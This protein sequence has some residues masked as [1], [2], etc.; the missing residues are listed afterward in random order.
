MP[1]EKTKSYY[2]LDGYP[3][4]EVYEIDENVM[5]PG[6]IPDE[7]A[8]FWMKDCLIPVTPHTLKINNNNMNES[9]QLVDGEPLTIPKRDKAQSISIDFMFPHYFY[10][11]RDPFNCFT[12]SKFI[13]VKNLTD[14][15]WNMKSNREP[16]VLTIIYIDGHRLNI[17]VMLDDYTYTQDGATGSDYDFSLTF[18]E[19]R[20]PLN[21][22]IDIELQN[23]LVRHNIRALRHIGGPMP[24][25]PITYETVTGKH[26]MTWEEMRNQI[27]A[28]LKEEWKKTSKDEYTNFDDV[29]RKWWESDEER[30]QLHCPATNEELKNWWID[31]MQL[32]D[33]EQT[34]AKKMAD[35]EAWLNVE[36]KKLTDYPPDNFWEKF[37]LWWR[38][39]PELENNLHRPVTDAE[40]F[41]WWDDFQKLNAQDKKFADIQAW[42]NAELRKISKNPPTEFWAGLK[43]WWDYDPSRKD[44]HCP[45]TKEELFNWWDDFM[46][47]TEADKKTIADI[48]HWLNEELKKLT[49]NPPK[50]F[51]EKFELWWKSDPL[52]DFLHCPDNDAEL[53]NWWKDFLDKSSKE[54]E[55]NK[56]IADIWHWLN[57][58]L[59]SLVLD[60]PDDFWECL[61]V[62]WYSD[63]T[64]RNTMHCPDDTEELFAWWDNFMEENKAN[65]EKMKTI[66]DYLD[67]ELK[68]LTEKPPSTFNEKLTLWWNSDPEREEGIPASQK[69]L[70]AWWDRYQT[71]KEEKM[72]EIEAFLDEEL[73]AMEEKSPETLKEKFDTWWNH[74]PDHRGEKP[75]TDVELL[76]WWR[77]YDKVHI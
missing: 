70:F 6:G 44:M 56:K 75:D 57:A 30:K 36:V 49:K 45:T 40:L 58:E 34:N 27:E 43:F 14:W 67:T 24:T 72:K 64:R 37:R 55:T 33:I 15:L 17:R 48:Q 61:R 69:D 25:T 35:I 73:E 53:I 3:P 9:D 12:T 65:A 18:T 39:Q 42:L 1:T 63:E 31:F 26:E 51:K 4:Y 5:N 21:Q 60:T 28:W 38:N 71:E 32:S 47:K 10:R 41:N 77:N 8:Q 52:R 68:G 11:F 29:F 13:H 50:T 66:E 20:E 54:E 7:A 62:W 74:W 76:V 23:T 22:E 16:F 46:N 19:Y 59:G 2:G